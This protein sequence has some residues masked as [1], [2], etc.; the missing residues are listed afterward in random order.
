MKI[1]G[2]CTYI[3]YVVTVYFIMMYTII[4]ILLLYV[5]LTN[6]ANILHTLESSAKLK[7]SVG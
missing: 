6:R 2:I 4:I 1:T 3:D 5:L 7:G